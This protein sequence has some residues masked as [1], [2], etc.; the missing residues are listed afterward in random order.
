[1]ST[2]SSRASSLATGRTPGNPRQTGQTRVF[3]SDPNSFAHPHHILER[4]RN[5]T[6]VSNPMT[7]S[8]SIR[9]RI[10][11]TGPSGVKCKRMALRVSGFGAWLSRV[12]SEDAGAPWRMPGGVRG[13]FAAD[14]ARGLMFNRFPRP[15]AAR[16]LRG[17][18]GAQ[19]RFTLLI[20]CQLEGGV[21]K[22][23]RRVP[24]ETSRVSANREL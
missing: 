13:R 24:P 3:G 12:C 14:S 10:S 23:A 8:Y 22:V 4:V 2:V 5:C 11:A 21:S 9:G 6:C 1:M 19:V 18:K 15:A 17:S 20:Q 7:A 16:T